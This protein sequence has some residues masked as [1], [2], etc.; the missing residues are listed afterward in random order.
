M[1]NATSDSYGCQQH[2][3]FR[4]NDTSVCRQTGFATPGS[5]FSVPECMD[6]G[7]GHLSAIKAMCLFLFHFFDGFQDQSRSRKSMFQIFRISKPQ[8]GGLAGIGK[9]PEA[10]LESRQPLLRTADSEMKIL[11][12]NE[13]GRSYYDALCNHCLKL[14]S[15]PSREKKN[16]H[17][18]LLR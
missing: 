3:H 11:I 14:E 5:F 15:A 10:E 18:E 8:T 17:N 4:Q 12:S 7:R 13:T 9:I 16:T 2:F 1:I 6:W